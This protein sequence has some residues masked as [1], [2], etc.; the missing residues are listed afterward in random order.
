ISHDLAVVAEM[1]DRIA[2]MR[3]GEIVEAGETGAT[4]SEQKHPYTRQL[5]EASSHR[6]TRS[7]PQK[8]ECQE[9]ILS[10]RDV[11]K[12]YRLPRENIFKPASF[13]KAVD[14]VSFDIAAGQSISLVGRSGCGKSTL[15][16]LILALDKPT[17]GEVEF[18]SGVTSQMDET[19]LRPYRRNMQIVFQD[20]YGSF[21]PRHKVERLVTEPLHLLDEKPSGKAR[22]DLAVAA[23]ESVG[24]SSSDL[25]K[26]PHEFSGGQRQRIS[27]ARAI[28]NKPKLI[29]CDEPVSALDVS[30]RAHILDLFADLSER[31]GVAYLF[32]THDLNV[33]RAITEEVMVM[34]EGLIVERGSTED[35]LSSPQSEAA[36]NLVSAM[37]VLEAAIARRNSK[38][39]A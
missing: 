8:E 4:L 15:A 30:V 36:K 26:Y 20:P 17:E 11:K 34:H 22:T 9:T 12:Y 21:D 33:A 29:V 2:I 16:R 28:I 23:L 27:I 24:L 18:M 7:E 13:F 31:L 39:T 35:V 37:P 25:A 6:P 5:A 38:F 14:G 10:V 32:I 1:A 3:S 19:T